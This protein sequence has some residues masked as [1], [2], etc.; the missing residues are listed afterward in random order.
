MSSSAEGD[1]QSDRFPL[2]HLTPEIDA[3]LRP[4]WATLIRQ[5][6]DTLMAGVAH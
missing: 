4:S 5:N 3:R 2:L 6:I 1:P